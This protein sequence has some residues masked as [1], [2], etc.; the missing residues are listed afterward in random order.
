MWKSYDQWPNTF[1][2]NRY[3][4]HKCSLGES[5][6]CRL[7]IQP[8]WC[9]ISTLLSCTHSSSHTTSDDGVQCQSTLRQLAKH[10][11]FSTFAQVWKRH[12]CRLTSI[13][14]AIT[15]KG[16]TKV[17]LLWELSTKKDW[18]SYMRVQQPYPCYCNRRVPNIIPKERRHLWT[19]Q[20]Y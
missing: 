7:A 18:W 8:S 12:F 3:S 6:Y 17:H 10:L 16:R 13:S 20:G 15:M 9:W 5:E 2:I 1:H 4:H 11:W 19:S 14:N